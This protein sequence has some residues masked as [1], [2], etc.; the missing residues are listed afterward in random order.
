LIFFL[1]N[2][3]KDG[4]KRTFELYCNYLVKYFDITL[5]TNTNHTNYLKE[6]NSKIKVVNPNN[7]FFSKF[8]SL[9]NI[10]CT[11]IALKFFGN[12][13]TIFSLDGHFWLLFSKFLGSKIKLALRIANPLYNPKNSE[14]KKFLNRRFFSCGP[15]EELGKLDLFFFKTAD[16]I[17][18]YTNKH[19]TYLKKNY[20]IKNL[21]IIRNY[22]SQK[23]VLT[24]KNKKIFRVYFIGR[25]HE[26]KDPKFFLRNIIKVQQEL[27][28][29]IHIV[30]SGPLKKDLKLMIRKYKKDVH[31]QGF[32]KEPFKKFNKKI[33]LFCL[34]SKFDGTPNVLGEAISYKIPC[35]APRD[36]GCVNELLNKGKYGT[37][38]SPNNDKD[39]RSKLKYS[40]N[41][42]KISIL[43]ANKAYLNLAM[44]NKKNT[45]EKLKNELL[46]I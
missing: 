15:G 40:L 10:Y 35:I 20:Q 38:Y 25:L 1:P 16:L 29:K 46:L 23:K 21:K 13:T 33:D 9:N 18:L 39:F 14:E 44:Y 11:Y 43:K 12:G 19:F 37:L 7:Y 41:N 6:I 26:S 5:I 31:L 30:G 32:V 17:T 28:I 8:Y 22:F 42:Y 24:K 36:V 45:L 2:I 4:L 3:T 34:T 27:K